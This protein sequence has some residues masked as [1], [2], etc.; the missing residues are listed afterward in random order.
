[1]TATDAPTLF[2][3]D[4]EEAAREHVVNPYGM[5]EERDRLRR[6]LV[7]CLAH[8]EAGTAAPG[9]R[10]REWRELA[11]VPYHDGLEPLDRRDEGTARAGAKWT[12][13]EQAQVDRAI[14]TVAAKVLRTPAGNT[15]VDGTFTA[16]NVWRELGP[17]FPVTKGLT[18]RLIAA[19]GK[20]IIRNTG[21]TT[22]AD[23]GG[24][25]DHGQRLTVWE[26][27]P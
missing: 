12:D 26:A 4:R 1:M 16:D 21:R 25:H 8:V 19:A 17:E 27:I 6:A 13:E 3:V 15:A 9:V 18:G 22:I 11:G 20:G 10:I 7:D 5:A 23:R 2:D 14:R 24:D